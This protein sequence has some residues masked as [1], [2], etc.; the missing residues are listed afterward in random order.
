MSQNQTEDREWKC[1]DD[2]PFECPNSG[3]LLKV[4]SATSLWCPNCGYTRKVI[5]YV[6]TEN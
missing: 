6:E 5:D 2:R 4:E 1:I 3:R